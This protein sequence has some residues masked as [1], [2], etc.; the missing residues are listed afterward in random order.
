LRNAIKKKNGYAKECDEEIKTEY[1]KIKSRV[2]RLHHASEVFYSAFPAVHYPHFRADTKKKVRGGLAK[3]WK[4]S[5]DW[6]AHGRHWRHLNDRMGKYGKEMVGIGEACSTMAH[7]V[8]GTLHSPGR[9]HLHHCPNEKCKKVTVRDEC[10][11]MIG[12]IGDVKILQRK[13]VL[14]D[15]RNGIS[16]P[17]SAN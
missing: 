8:C 1:S 14:A 2:R 6:L 12:V 4:G 7:C 17:A 5:F 3:A 15:G 10:A 9:H 11:R 13:A 16:A